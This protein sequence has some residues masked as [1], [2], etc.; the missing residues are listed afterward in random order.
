MKGDLTKRNGMPSF[1]RKELVGWRLEKTEIALTHLSD[2]TTY[3][4]YWEKSYFARMNNLG[5][6]SSPTK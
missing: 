6:S 4:A 3:V 1:E 5:T 2:G